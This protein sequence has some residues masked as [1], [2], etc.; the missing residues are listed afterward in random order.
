MQLH[1]LSKAQFLVATETTSS[2]ALSDKYILFLVLILWL[3]LHPV[4]FYYHV[5]FL[6]RLASSS[7]IMPRVG[8]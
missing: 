7:P 4:L 5:N 1:W 2:E 3:Q 8:F 6:I